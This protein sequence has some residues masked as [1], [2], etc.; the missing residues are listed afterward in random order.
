MT[1]LEELI[2]ADVNLSGAFV[3]NNRGQILAGA[4]LT[5]VGQPPG[6]LDHDCR[7]GIIDFL[8]LLGR[9]GETDSAADLDGDGAVNGV[10][11]AILLATWSA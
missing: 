8:L 5:P 4:V 3:V 9:W 11:L 6:D 1:N 10:D 2:D 7:V